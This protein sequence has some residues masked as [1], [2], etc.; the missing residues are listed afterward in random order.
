MSL[1]ELARA[2]LNDRGILTASLNPMQMV[3]LAFTH[4]TSDFGNIL[5]DTAAVSVLAGW[6]EA[7]ETFDQWTRRGRLSDFRVAKRVGMGHSRPCVRFVLV[8]STNTSPPATVARPSA[9]PPTASCSR[10]PARRSSTMT[11]TC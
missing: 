2:S 4:D 10:S 8:L 5:I 1:R 11:S 7:P 9:W 3:G 6:D